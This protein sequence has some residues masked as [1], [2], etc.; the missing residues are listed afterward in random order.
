MNGDRLAGTTGLNVMLTAALAGILLA[1]MPAVALATDVRLFDF[2]GYSYQGDFADLRSDGV[3]NLNTKSASSL[4][5]IELWASALPH[6]AGMPGVRMALFPLDALDPGTTTGAI[7]SGTVAFLRPP[8]GVWHFAMMLTEYTGTDVANDGY[9][10]RY[11][12]NFPE[13]EYI[14]VPRPPNVIGAIEYYHT[15]MDHYFVATNPQEIIDLDTGVHPG[16][17]RTGFDF[18]VWDSA[19]GFGSP[20]CRF[21]IPPGYG[22]SH[23]F[24]ASPAECAQTAAKFPWL[25]RETDAA[26]YVALPDPVTGAC[27]GSQR[28]VYRLWNGRTDSNHRYAISASIKASMLAN[29]YIAE[30]YGPDQV[31]MCAPN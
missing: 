15:G 11:W 16:W 1:I 2:V 7:D 30:G 14:G 3:R 27:A 29:G 21:Y 10:V 4:L 19:G 5:R 8:A 12:I 9:V 23:F 20:V 31:A 25:T 22:D 18:G 26:F 6:T 17:M 13:P 28:P 24:S